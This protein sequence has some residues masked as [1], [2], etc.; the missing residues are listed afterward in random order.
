MITGG[1]E[2]VIGMTTDPVFGPL[3]MFGLG[4]VYVEVMKD[5]TFKIHPLTDEWARE[6]VHSLKSYPLLD[7]FRGAPPVDKE[8]LEE[9]LLK[10]SQLLSDFDCFSEIDINPFIVSANRKDCAAVD[11]RFLLRK[12]DAG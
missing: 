9:T 5:V 6:M 12:T 11:A 4:G 7:G 8:V 2:T 3:I 1:L 10:V